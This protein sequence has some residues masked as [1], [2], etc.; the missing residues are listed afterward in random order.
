[1]VRRVHYAAASQYKVSVRFWKYD[2]GYQLSSCFSVREKWIVFINL[3][4]ISIIEYIPISMV[5]KKN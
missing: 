2:G 4:L 3:S 5:E 1:M